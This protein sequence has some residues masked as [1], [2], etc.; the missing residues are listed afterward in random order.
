MHV[1]AESGALASGPPASA[2]FPPDGSVVPTSWF[3]AT[4]AKRIDV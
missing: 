1:R 2:C 3:L 4:A